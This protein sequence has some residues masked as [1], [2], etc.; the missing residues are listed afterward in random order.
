M[1][2]ARRSNKNKGGGLINTLI[3]KLPIEH[4][5]PGYQYC[6]PGTNLKKRLARGDKGINLLD[7]ACRDHDI[8]YERS[9]SIADR[10]KADYIL[11]QRAWDRFKSKDSSLKEKAVAWGVTTAMKAKRKVGGGCGFKAALKASKN[12]IKKNIGEKNLMKLT[13]KCV[14]VARKAFKTKKT[15]VPR[16]INIPKKGGVLP[17]IPIFA[18][19]SALGAL[20]GGVANV[21]K[22]AN[23]FNRNTPSHL[24]KGL[25]LTPYKGNSYQI[26]TPQKSG[27]DVTAD[28]VDDCKI[29]QMQYHSF[30]PY[31]NASF[32]YN[33]EI[34]INI[35]N[36]DSY[37]LPCESFLYIEGNVQ[38]PS[39]TV[40]DVRFSNN[41]LAFLFSEMR[42]EINGIEIQKL[43]SPGVSSCL[44][45]YCSYTPNDLNTLDNCA[46]DTEMDG[47]DNKNFMTDNVFAGC[48]PL[49][50]LFGFCEDYKKILL[51]CNQQLILNR[52]STDLNAIR[53]VGAG[54]TENVEKNKKITIELTKV[55][56]K[57][58][59]IKVTDKEKLK[60]LKV[61]DSRK[62]LSCAFRTWDLCEYPVLPRNTSHSWT[63]KS[64]SLLEKPRFILFGLQTD[65]K[66][67]IEIDAGRFDHC[68]L[69]NLKVHL[70]SEVFPYEDFRADFKKNT[71]CLL[72]KAYTDFQKSYYERDY[73]EPLLT[74]NVF[75]TYVPIVVVDLSYQNDNVKSSTIDLRIE[76]ETNT[77]IPEKTA[78]YCLILHDQIITYNPF[79]GDVRKFLRFTF[80]FFVGL[81]TRIDG[82]W[83]KDVG[84]SFSSTARLV[85]GG[86][87]RLLYHRGDC[88][89]LS[90]SCPVE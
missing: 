41:G 10:N 34:R 15:R 64:S 68:Q 25:Y 4:H 56:W 53:V 57:M 61:L 44:K 38:K 43:K 88:V 46:W 9:N 62:T 17:L 52:S 84:P 63:I 2:L 28:Y 55:A 80:R 75:Q 73:C 54:A 35:Q 26:E 78:A 39:D 76:F 27:G 7:S 33:D 51:N 42:Y 90:E 60:L 72:Y 79:S 58:P 20:T 36:M 89:K 69:K 65:R 5:V 71:T 13:K 81:L 14:A 19:L 70:N 29:T 82:E 49:K 47:E 77:V 67:N 31:S 16:T 30:T 32:S 48:I 12:V 59:I 3:N 1:S 18:G 6:G 86:L 50:H 23:E 45:A 87:T 21:V 83:L 22:V 74:K 11:E 66:K 24:G 40:G 37:T 8:A 85:G